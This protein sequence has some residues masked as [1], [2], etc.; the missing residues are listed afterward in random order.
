MQYIKTNKRTVPKMYK[1]FLQSN[2]KKDKPPNRKRS[3]ILDQTVQNRNSELPINIGKD[4]DDQ[5]GTRKL[6]IEATGI[7]FYT[8]CI[9]KHVKCL[10]V[11]HVADYIKYYTLLV[12]CKLIQPLWENN[13]A[14]II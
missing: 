2:E 4:T 13:F 12:K 3:G 6:Q 11:L 8:Y 9:S 10:S 14:F 1:K 7:L 5:L